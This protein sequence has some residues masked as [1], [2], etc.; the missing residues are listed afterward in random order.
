VRCLDYFGVGC[1]RFAA[2]RTLAAYY[3]FIAVVDDAIDSGE[4]Q[5]GAMV[6]QHLSTRSAASEPLP[7]DVAVITENLKRELDYQIDSCLR[8]QFWLLYETVSHEKAAKSIDAY[9][10]VRKAVGQLTAD[11]SYLLIS[12]LLERD[13]VRLRAFMRKVGAVGCLVDSVIDLDADKRRGLLS[14][15]PTMR[16]W[17]KLALITCGEGLSIALRHPRLAGLFLMSILDTI[18]DRFP[19]SRP[20]RTARMRNILVPQDEH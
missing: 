9:T 19:L 15:Q 8:D 14:F 16:D 13:S 18:H 20:A 4:T 17:L 12:P 5:V 10:E 1:D 6:L 7:T 11:L 2:A 3:L